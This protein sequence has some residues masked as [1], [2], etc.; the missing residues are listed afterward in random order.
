MRLQ[1]AAAALLLASAS[2]FGQVTTAK[3]TFTTFNSGA[4]HAAASYWHVNEGSGTNLDDKAGS[5]DLTLTTPDWATDGTHGP[6]LNFVAANADIA[7]YTGLANGL[8]GTA[9]LCAILDVPADPGSVAIMMSFGDSAAATNAAVRVQ[10]T[11]IISATS[12]LATVVDSSNSSFDVVAT[13]GMNLVCLKISDSNVAVSMNG[14]AWHNNATTHTGLVASLDEIT[15]G[16]EGDNATSNWTEL[17]PLV[18]AWMY[19]ADKDDAAIAAI[20]NSGNPWNVIGVETAPTFTAGPTE[21]TNS[22]TDVLVTYTASQSGTLHWALRNSGS[23]AYA[24]CAA[25]Q[26]ASGAIDADSEATS[27]D[28]L[29][30]FVHYEGDIDLCLD[31]AGGESAVATLNDVV[32]NTCSGCA[33]RE[34]AAL[35]DTSPLKVPVDTTGDTDHDGPGA[36]NIITGMAATTLFAVGSLVTVSSGFASTGPFLI[37]SKT[38]TTITVDSNAT[39]T[40]SNVTVTGHVN[41]AGTTLISPTPAAGDWLEYETAA[42]NGGTVSFDAGWDVDY[43][44]DTGEELDLAALSVCPQDVS[45]TTPEFAAPLNCRTTAFYELLVNNAP[46]TFDIAAITNIALPV[47]TPIA[48]IALDS[49]CTHTRPVTVEVRAGAALPMGLTLSNG[50]I[51]GTLAGEHESPFSTQL[52]CGVGDLWSLQTW[53]A[54]GITSVTMIDLVGLDLNAA[55]TGAIDTL[56]AAFPW[57]DQGLIQAN[58]DSGT[59]VAQSPAE[60]EQLS[61]DEAV[62]LTVAGCGGGGPYR[63]FFLRLDLGN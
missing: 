59:V 47:G 10:T 20:Y 43:D 11:G 4:T 12:V 14:A 40:A 33:A 54:Y 46:P 22:A 31:T 6:V 55:G 36:A 52:W 16:A 49:L 51:A 3:P 50:D 53:T 24:D 2:A 17:T 34:L 1:L 61:P 30:P 32:R 9:I 44:P 62:V 21:S 42:D 25:V 7:A 58:C 41:T 5:R 19:T 13:A 57:Y 39:S 60:G 18:A 38:D 56:L 26:A 48:T 15:I 27:A 37:Q 23:S 29:I 63:S 8:T 45:D 28:V 35:S